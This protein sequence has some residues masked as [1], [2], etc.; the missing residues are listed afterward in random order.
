M[1]IGI[2][3][4]VRVAGSQTALGKLIGVSPQAVQ[5]WVG[6]GV[7]PARRCREIE[8]KLFGAVTRYEL[9]K[10]AFGQPENIPREVS[11]FADE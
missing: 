4:A 2:N 6:Q 10:E 3:K 1:E 9:N 8:E 11:R 7:A 5:K